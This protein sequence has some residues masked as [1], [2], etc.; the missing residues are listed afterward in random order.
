MESKTRELSLEQR[1]ELINT[2]RER[3]ANNMKR[4]QGFSWDRI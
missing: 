2:L 4:H 1:E 3:F